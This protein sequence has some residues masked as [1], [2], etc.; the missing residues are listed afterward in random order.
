[1][2]DYPGQLY[3]A[4]SGDRVNGD[5]LVVTNQCSR[6]KNCS[7]TST[8]Q[9][10]RAAWTRSW[11]ERRLFDASGTTVRSNMNT[12]CRE[13]AT[14]PGR[15][16]GRDRWP[17]TSSG[18]SDLHAAA[19]VLGSEWDS[20]VPSSPAPELTTIR[21]CDRRAAT[22]SHD[23][24]QGSTALRHIADSIGSE[25][26]SPSSPGDL[27]EPRKHGIRLRST[28]AY[29]S[30]SA[31]RVLCS[32][33]D[34]GTSQNIGPSHTNRATPTAKFGDTRLLVPASRRPVAHNVRRAPASV[35]Q[36]FAEVE[37]A[38]HWARHSL[39]TPW[40]HFVS[41]TAMFERK[42]RVR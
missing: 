13:P 37:S 36:R 32:P 29:W 41:L 9:R 2:L 34:D 40:L 5:E 22:N 11:A 7:P 6:P 38:E 10:N 16:S 19:M 3:S 25:P 26:T 1:M 30:Y 28:Q 23:T 4:C 31:R 12:G 42:R 21:S 14:P 27:V 39:R 18:R 17:R 15:A 33:Q 8:S 35:A 20:S 24:A